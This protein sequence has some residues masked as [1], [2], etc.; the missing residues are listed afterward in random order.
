MSHPI[1][2][3]SL[4]GI[5]SGAV[6]VA[7]LVL[8]CVTDARERKIPNLLVGLLSIGGLLA[9]VAAA[10]PAA[11]GRAL[12]AGALGFAIWIPF[13]AL[14]M[15]GAGDVKFFA[16][17][18]LWLTPGEVVHAAFYTAVVG[19]GLSVLWLVLEYGAR[20]GLARAIMVYQAPVA[21]AREARVGGPARRH[22][23]YGIAMAAG[24]TAA[25]WLPHLR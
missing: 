19:A 2:D 21:A 25:A 20:F 18:A 9:V 3:S 1:T 22:I 7:L 8:G 4:L 24:L 23:P 6:F 12:A 15:L 5:V 14:R 11:L 17:A 10:G 16:A 13:Y